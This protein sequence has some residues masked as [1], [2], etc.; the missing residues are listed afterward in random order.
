[1]IG[2]SNNVQTAS[3]KSCTV[4]TGGFLFFVA[5]PEASFLN[6]AR[7]HVGEEVR[8]LLLFRRPSSE[9]GREEVSRSP[10]RPC[11]GQFADRLSASAGDAPSRGARQAA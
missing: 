4:L 6:A 8:T 10:R 1:M 2:E 7:D 11:A 3:A 5:R 9:I